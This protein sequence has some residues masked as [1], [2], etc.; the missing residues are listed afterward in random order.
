MPDK[1]E[2][3]EEEQFHEA[4]KIS[5]SALQTGAKKIKK[6]AR[7]LDVTKAVEK[8]IKDLGGEM[9]FPVNISQNERAAHYTCPAGDETVFG[10]DLVKLDV[11]AHIDGYIGDNALTV[12]ISGK[13]TKLVKA[14]EDALKN[15]VNAI[16]PGVKNIEIGTII[17]ETIEKAGFKPVENL[18]GHV[19]Q[20]NLLHTGLSIPNMSFGSEFEIEEGMIIAI[21]PFAT[22]GRGHVTEDRQVEIFSLEKPMPVRNAEARKVLAFVMENYQFLPFAERWLENVA[23]GFKLK[24]A[25]KELVTRGVFASYPVLKDIDLV[26]Q[27]EW[28]IIVTKDG[29]E[30]T[31]K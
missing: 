20:Q 19:I 9:A 2:K 28:T 26:S 11:G 21:E 8:K 18:C 30:R 12:D 1:K 6:G 3:T 29:C 23:S 22:L 5:Y 16:A 4:G 24:V 14:S 27:T 25:L 7:L 13:N 31:T 10:L 17:Q 15:A